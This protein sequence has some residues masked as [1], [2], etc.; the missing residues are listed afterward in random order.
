MTKN[1]IILILITYCL[2]TLV[3]FQ[4]RKAKSTVEMPCDVQVTIK[5]L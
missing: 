4:T 1:F 2:I 5:P 3:L